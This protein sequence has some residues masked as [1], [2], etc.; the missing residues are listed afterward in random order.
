M[1]KA[2]HADFI[3]AFHVKTLW[4]NNC[5]MMMMMSV[6]DTVDFMTWVSVSDTVVCFLH[7]LIQLPYIDKCLYLSF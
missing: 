6:S 5:S 3:I 1:S 7:S 4:N 2:V